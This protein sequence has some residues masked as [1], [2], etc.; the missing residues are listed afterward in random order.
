MDSLEDMEQLFEGIP[1]GEI[2]TSM[3]INAPAHVLLALYI[4]AGEKQGVP[5]E[6]LA[7]TNQN[8]ILKEYIAQ[9]EWIFPP[10]PSM[11]VFK[12]M[13]V[14]ATEHMPKWRPTWR[15]TPSP[16][17]SAKNRWSASRSSKRAATTRRSRSVSRRSKKQPKK[18]RTRCTR[19]SR[20]YAPT[21][22]CRRSVTP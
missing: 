20:P 1:M 11:Q 13:L 5:P 17:K 3:T 4:V 2:T 15:R 14:Y 18:A 7:G 19:P 16:K 10:E 6:E 22:P 9:K 12:D 8:D 21:P